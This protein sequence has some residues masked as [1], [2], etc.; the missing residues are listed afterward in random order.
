MLVGINNAGISVGT[1]QDTHGN[2]LPAT[3]RDRDGAFPLGAVA[4]AFSTNPAAIND[5]G[6]ITGTYVGQ[7]QNHGFIRYP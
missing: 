3:W 6:V 1:A 2:S 5:H 7:N 4:G